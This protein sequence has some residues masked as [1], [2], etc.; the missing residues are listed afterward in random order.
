MPLVCLLLF[1]LFFCGCGN[2]GS[3][4]NAY[5]NIYPLS[6]FW[7]ELLEKELLE[8]TSSSESMSGSQDSKN[9]TCTWGRWHRLIMTESLRR[10]E[11]FMGNFQMQ[12]RH[13]RYT[14][15]SWVL[16]CIV[17]VNVK[18]KHPNWVINTILTLASFS[19]YLNFEQWNPQNKVINVFCGNKII[20][21]QL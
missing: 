13:Q 9:S 1:V 4:K 10:T 17:L 20:K 8:W 5:P 2:G 14:W 19:F 15:H 6:K 12:T 21:W 11:N 16:R 18:Y 7:K 3:G